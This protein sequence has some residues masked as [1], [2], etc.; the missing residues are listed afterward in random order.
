MSRAGELDNK[1]SESSSNLVFRNAGF[2]V[3]IDLSPYLPVDATLSPRQLEFALAQR[4]VDAG[5]FLHPGEEHSQDVGWFRLVFS[6]EEE[7]IKE[8]L[9]R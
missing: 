4:L 5:V 8:G 6:Q 9:V 7:I 1:L 3:Y 2:F